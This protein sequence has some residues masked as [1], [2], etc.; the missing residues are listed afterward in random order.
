MDRVSRCLQ[1]L[2]PVY[3]KSTERRSRFSSALSRRGTT[4]FFR[5]FDDFYIPTDTFSLNLFHSSLAVSTARGIEVLTLDKKLPLSIPTDTTSPHVATIA[6]RIKDQRPLG[7]FRLS[8]S[9]FL[10]AYDECAVYVNKHGDVSRGVIME[11]VGRPRSATLAGPYLLLFDPDFVEVR[12]AHNGRLR[13][14]VPGRDVRCLDDG[15]PAGGNYNGLVQAVYTEARGRTVKVGLQ[16]PEFERV[17]LVV[18]LEIGEGMK[19]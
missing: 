8:E 19:E 11:F 10:L 13:Q 9:E 17:Q 2:E 18:E 14:V 5:D 7:M 15:R 12:N 3:Q 4:E 16:H 1:V 6:A